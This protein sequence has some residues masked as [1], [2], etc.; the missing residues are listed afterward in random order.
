M[1]YYIATLGSILSLSHAILNKYAI[2]NVL[3]LMVF[4]LFKLLKMKLLIQNWYIYWSLM[5]RKP[6]NST[7]QLSINNLQ[8]LFRV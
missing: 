5:S 3:I 7:T 6:I 1:I 8:I 4:E 2:W